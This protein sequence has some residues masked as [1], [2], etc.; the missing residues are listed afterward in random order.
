MNTSMDTLDAFLDLYLP[1]Y[2][3]SLEYV[4]WVFSLLGSALIG[5][6]GILPLIIIPSDADGK[7]KEL[8]NRKSFNMQPAKFDLDC[9]VSRAF[10]SSCGLIA[11]ACAKCII[12]PATLSVLRKKF[13]YFLANYLSFIATFLSAW[14]HIRR[15]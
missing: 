8:K 3:R 11:R 12:L 14:I 6:S 10:S 7:D 13:C 9:I 2:I 5:L 4:P 1:D 15:Q